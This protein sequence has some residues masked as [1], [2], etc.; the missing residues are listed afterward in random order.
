M[1]TGLRRSGASPGAAVAFFLGNPTLNPA[2]L[3]FLALTLGWRWAALRLVLGLLLV[4]GL[5]V[6]V[7]RVTSQPAAG[8]EQL[9]AEAGAPRE[10]RRLV[11][12]WLRSF[13]RLALWLVPEYVVIVALLGAARGL[14]FPA[15]GPALGNG[16]L[17]IVLF[18]LVGMLFVIPTAGEIPIIMTMMSFGV[19]AGPAGALLLTLAPVSLPSLAMVSRVFP[20][21]VLGVLAA[22]TFAMGVLGGLLAVV[23]R[24]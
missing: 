22:G 10:P 1:V 18:A 23:L 7:S 13:A 15:V 14:L 2:V 6:L 8:V 16:V 24:F 9:V 3:G 20:A 4:L 17:V 19:G 5:A 12:A 11:V 21:R